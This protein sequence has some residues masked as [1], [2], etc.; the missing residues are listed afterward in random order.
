[1]NLLVAYDRARAAIAEAK[2][3]KAT[4]QI[5]DQL[6]HV[7]LHA[8]QVQN[9]DLL[10]DAI[11]LQLRCER[12][13]GSMLDAA[14]RSGELR[15]PG[16]RGKAKERPAD[17]Q[18]RAA[19]LKEIG[20]DY[21]LS[22][23]SRRAA[24]LGD[25]A[26]EEIV[27]GARDKAKSGNAILIDPIKAAAKTAEIDKRRAD[28]AA[29]TIGGGGIADLGKMVREG[30]KFGSIGSDPQWKFLT[31]SAAGE[32]RSANIHYKTEEVDKIKNLPVGELL[33]DD[34][35]F[36]MWMV[37]WCPQDALDLLAHYGLQH[38]TTAFTWIKTNGDD[39]ELD[40]WDD[41]SFHMGQGYWTRANPEVCWFATKTDSKKKPKR[42]YAD[43]RQLIIAP[44]MEH[45]RKPDAW[46]DR[47]ERLTPGDYLELQARRTRP[48]WVSWGDELEF[49]GVAA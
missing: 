40:L 12:H 13:L 25:A 18:P 22:A 36:Y 38:I 20:V 45:S 7:K 4:L 35:A 46:L 21:K 44:L 30:R 49:T 41:S 26:F 48:G 11:E 8:K 33:A 47:I 19:T 43:V 9:R 29:R 31:R 42:L 27:A 14:E 28:H 6:E 16:E 37:D 15:A 10:A 34:G 39:P 17:D 5:R 32:G 23:T 24:A 1:M 2:T 3:V